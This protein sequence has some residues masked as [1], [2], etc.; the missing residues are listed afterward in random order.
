MADKKIS[1]LNAATTPLAGTEEIALTQGGETRRTPVSNVLTPPGGS[2]GQVQFKSGT[3]FAGDAGLTFN[4]TNDILTVGVAGTST[5]TVIVG[6]S[7]SAADA[8]LTTDANHIFAQ[9]NATNPQT[10]RLY[11]T[12]TDASNYE[13]G[14]MRWNSNVLEI[15]LEAAGSGSVRTFRILA[16]NNAAQPTNSLTISCSNQSTTYTASGSNSHVFG[17]VNLN[18]N[19]NVSNTTFAQG[20]I[21]VQRNSVETFTISGE[22]PTTNI[23]SKKF[24]IVG[25]TAFATATGANITGGTVVLL[26]GDGASASAGAANGGSIFLDGGIGYG[27][28]VTGSIIVGST[29]YRVLAFGGTTS[30]FPAL[31]HSSATLVARLADDSAN[32]AFEAASVR[33]NAPTGGTAATWRLGTVATVTPTSPN[34][35]IE[36]E[37]GGTTYYIHAKTTN[38]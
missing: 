1:Q 30:S 17:G 21:T 25:G 3:T 14:F 35:T 2:D 9:R 32:A 27:T 6:N 22:T 28:G 26:G 20:S 23:A 37:I 8:R 15:G 4:S 5:G 18:A 36:V 38:D 24:R 34:R 31:K 12:F 11:N 10:F 19:Q 7:A 16:T 13:R 29:R 33:T